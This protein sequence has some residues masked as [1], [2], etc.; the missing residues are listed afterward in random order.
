MAPSPRTRV[1]SGWTSVPGSQWR[2]SGGGYTVM[3]QMVI[4]V[5]GKPFP[6]FMQE[7]V[8]GPLT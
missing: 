4:D 7:A 8:L 2:Y 3:Q 6:Q 5:T 1:P